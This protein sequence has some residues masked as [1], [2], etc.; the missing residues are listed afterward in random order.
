MYVCG[1]TVY[2][3]AHIGNARP[4]VVF[5]VLAR[6]LRHLYPSVIYARNITDIDDKINKAAIEQG[7]DINVITERYIQAYHDDLQALKVLPPD[8]EPRV[9]THIA[10]IL[11]MIQT[12]IE[13][14]HA[15]EA[16]GHVL[17][18]VPSFIG[19]GELSGRERDDMIAGARVEVAPYKKD[20][21]DF[22]LW[23]PSADDQPGWDS[24]WGRGRPG[25]HIEC[26]VMIET[27]L[28]ETIDIHGGGNDLI[29]PHHENENAQ[30]TCAH[31][32]HTLCRYWV[33]NGFVNVEKEKMSKSLGNVLLVRELLQQAPGEA[34]RMAL[35]NA[36]YRAPLDWSHEVLQQA[37]RRL[38][39]LY[40]T[41]RDLQDVDELADRK[42]VTPQGFIEALSDDLNTPIALAELADLSRRAN[43][44][45]SDDERRALKTS[46]L[47]AGEMLG[48]LQEEPEQWFAGQRGDV[49]ADKIQKLV[50]ARTAARADKNFSRA[51]EIRA[52]LESMGVAIEDRADG[53]RWRFES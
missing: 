41:L 40:Q 37:K 28:G 52:Q 2:S 34:V 9:T 27:H 10:Q 21:A 13:S 5:D 29:F 12:L 33:H 42:T 38:D 39:G 32:G 7:V 47:A 18:H 48:L 53:T 46:L 11:H 24:A 23:K 30:S 14:G 3:Y 49:D 4:A 19:Y 20:P 36:H 15:Y 26:S 50:D 51:D 44:A 16:E 8:I 1:P 35:L 17:F 22:V 43:K 6:L 45:Q 31:A 25:W